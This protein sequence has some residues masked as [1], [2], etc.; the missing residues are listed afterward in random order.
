M[1]R[2]HY[3]NREEALESRFI[4]QLRERPACIFAADQVIV[5]SAA[6]RRSLTL[7]L[8]EH[9][10]ICANVRF[11]F[12][13][14][15]L[16]SQVRR[17]VPAPAAE[18]PY[19]AR[20]LTW[21]IFA[22]FGDRSFLAPHPR[23]VRYLG[24]ADEVMRYQLASRS[25]T[26]F[27][28]YVTYRPDWLAAWRSG[29]T[30]RLDRADA[31][32][33]ADERWQAALWRRLDA[34][35]G[36][37]G[38]DA[39]TAFVEALRSGGAAAAARAGIVGP[40]HVFALPTMPPL[41]LGLLDALG[42]VI[43]V[44]VYVLNPCRE[45]WFDVVAARRL[46]ALQTRGAEAGHEV[47]NRLLASWGQQTQSHL[48]LLAEAS[49]GR[50]EETHDFS[51]SC[52]TTLLGR[53]QNAIL[54][55][56][57]LEAGSV[58][59]T[60][61]DRSIEVHVC[62]SMT[63]EL[64]VL[65]D[66]LLS[67]FAAAGPG[68]LQPS[69]VLVVTPDLDATGPLID[70]VFGTA[71]RQRFIPYAVTGRARSQV[72]APA[73]ALLALLAL[74]GS[75]FPSS[76]VF[77]LLQLAIVARAY[78]LDADA[79][80][81]VHEWMR[82]AGSRW[83]LDAEHRASFDVPADARHTL[84]DAMG[85][86]YLGYA[87]PAQGSEPVFD[88]LP[89][90]DAEGSGAV[91]LGAFWRF[92]E[93]LRALQAAAAKPRTA[94]AWSTLL[95]DAI[96][97]FTEPAGDEI[98]DGREVQAAVRQLC[99][100]MAAGGD[101]RLPLGVVRAALLQALD[102]PSRGSV[103]GGAVT[104]SSMAGL[105][106]LPYAVVCVI[107]MND[108]A[109]PAT[110]RPPEYDLM[111]LQPRPGDRQ[112]RIDERNLFLDLLLAARQCLHI[113][114]SGRSLRD[115][116]PLPPSVLVAEL[117]DVVVPAIAEDPARA[118]DVAAAHARLVVEHP[119][120]PFSPQAF[121][122]DADIRVRSFDAELAEA[123]RQGE[124][125]PS[126]AASAVQQASLFDSGVEPSVV[127]G[128]EPIIAGSHG[129][130]GPHA[131]SGHGTDPNADLDA[132]LDT[133][134]APD[135]EADPFFAAPLASPGPAWRAVSLAQLA[136]FF[137]N[138][139]RFLLRRRLG[140]DF[141]RSAREAGDDEPFLPNILGRY[142]LSDRLLP[143]LLRGAT[144]EAARRLAEAGVE[145]PRGALGRQ[146]LDGELAALQRFVA[147]V[148][149]ETAAPFLPPHET[150][151]DL[152]LDGE[153][154]Q[155]KA[156]FADL[157]PT[158]LVRWQYDELRA[159]HALGLWLAH[160]LLCADPPPHMQLQSRWLALDGSLQLAEPAQPREL[161]RSLLRIYRDG[162]SVPA[163]FFPKS[164]WACWKNGSENRG[165]ARTAWKVTRAMRYSEGSD[166]A[167]RLALRGRGEP[168]DDEFHRLARTVFEPLVA[169]RV[170]AGGSP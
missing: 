81:Q 170:T 27:E 125:A 127:A 30:I 13:A 90:G 24:H 165:A 71:P 65:H 101:E 136:E 95:L 96:Q 35:L 100:D 15:W 128:L 52:E 69:Q 142:A 168:L 2:L 41:H 5:P 156:A 143:S 112:R 86:L 73:Q 56:A 163:R 4:V 160:L 88:M 132:D 148:G 14:H 92:V 51:P 109:F 89:S 47:G 57:E 22:A 157:R 63:R 94:A 25:A 44:H 102:D 6:V 50:G 161:L 58:T 68:G 149:V 61:D 62:H 18:P 32:A 104:F 145:L 1:L 66:R 116:A 135:A 26:L 138:P 11:E 164:A 8:A 169:H 54:D 37:A 17:L 131:G 43:D 39:A 55:L 146:H 80:A 113:S 21:R 151:L 85:R 23:L 78:D 118:A 97:T 53:L 40:V 106:S 33:Q 48:G 34:D 60:S 134:L 31:A 130:A 129:D 152:D 120:Q 105:R 158:G 75:R 10:G 64:E 162:L 9:D 153:A 144:P 83:A 36:G 45:Y 19:A 29:R 99:S 72:N 42:Q 98:E 59:L 107:G 12:L 121:A 140:I 108:G 38:A 49:A 154:W 70:A 117:L 77:G 110:S 122:A 93:D 119:L 79:L 74:A 124:P 137:S 133:D 91:I 115:N 20:T 123:L 114:Y 84:A 16:W 150:S 167:F 141:G 82:D 139:S 67:L 103:P 111:A 46:A 166:A 159:R 76:E 126:V 7:A 28:Q 147:R 87:L 155:L 3:S